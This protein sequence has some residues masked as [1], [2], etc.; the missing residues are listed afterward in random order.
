MFHGNQEHI[1][2]NA[3]KDQRAITDQEDG[4]SSLERNQSFTNVQENITEVPVPIKLKVDNLQ[5]SNEKFKG[6][7]IV[8]GLKFDGVQF[9]A[10]KF[11]GKSFVMLGETETRWRQKQT[12][13]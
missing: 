9:S 5:I 10:I 2:E 3:E 1:S 4:R 13:T 8:T 6:K 11:Q 7:S 12:K